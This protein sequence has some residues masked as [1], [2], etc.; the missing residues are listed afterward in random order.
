MSEM[1]PQQYGQ[2][3][4]TNT[5]AIISLVSGILSFMGLSCIGAIAAIILGN[6]AKNQIRETGEQGEGL[7]KAGV[8]LGWI[9]IV[10]TVIITLIVVL[11]LVLGIGAAAVQGN[12][13]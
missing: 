7:A 6:M 9:N 13:G 12:G 2:Q 10:L 4:G 8:I 1:P 11:F 3:A 5:L